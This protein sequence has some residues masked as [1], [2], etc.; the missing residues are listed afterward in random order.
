VRAVLFGLVLGWLVLVAVWFRR[1][2]P[3]LVAGLLVIGAGTLAAALAGALG[4]A[5]LGLARPRSWPLT[6][7]IAA[8]WTAVMLA[9]SPLADALA[10]RRF[11]QRPDLSAFDEIRRSRLRLVAGIV[12]AWVLGGFLEELVFRGVVLRSVDSWLGNALPQP[13]AATVA[14][15]AAALGA[16]VIHLYQGPRAA[17][18]ILQLSTLFGLVMVLSGGNLWAVV[19]S[20]GLY[21]TVAFIRYANRTSRY[22]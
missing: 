10:R 5:D 17:L 6:I 16:T 7:G 3:V 19:I 13:V 14:V 2:R 12:V 18:I 11:P 21:D 22:A 9:Y 15:V 1:S 8:G 20:H 4:P